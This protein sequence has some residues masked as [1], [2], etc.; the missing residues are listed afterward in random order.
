MIK[1]LMFLTYTLFNTSPSVAEVKWLSNQFWQIPVSTEY[2]L[3]LLNIQPSLAEEC[4]LLR[5]YFFNDKNLLRIDRIEEYKK[6]INSPLTDD[7][8]HENFYL[9]FKILTSRHLEVSE[10]PHLVPELEEAIPK[11]INNKTTL[12]KTVRS[13]E[14]NLLETSLLS[15]FN[16]SFSNLSLASRG[17]SGG[18][19]H[20]PLKV[21]A[22]PTA[23]YIVL[24]SKD[25]ACDLLEG[26]ASLS[27]PGKAIAKIHWKNQEEVLNDFKPLET[28]T[29]QIFHENTKK[30]V[31]AALIGFKL[32]Q[33][34]EQKIPTENIES[35][36]K[37]LLMDFFDLGRMTP[38]NFWN[39]NSDGYTFSIPDSTSPFEMTLHLTV[40]N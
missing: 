4:R 34:L 13:E 27:I 40:N 25:I 35:E 23:Y 39:E 33:Y 32:G 11:Q 31:R 26:N 37:N 30:S 3:K 15:K 9:E 1:N 38:S 10:L 6:S 36:L 14:I 5:T 12:K 19:L 21:I 17:I 7:K 2:H 8:Y 16:I 18:I 20:P 24:Q 29:N 28:I 22:R